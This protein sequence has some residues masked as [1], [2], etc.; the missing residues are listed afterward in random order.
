MDDFA[1]FLEQLLQL[2]LVERDDGKVTL[3]GFVEMFL[4]MR[5]FDFPNICPL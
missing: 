3:E 2:A 5:N 4:K 1:A